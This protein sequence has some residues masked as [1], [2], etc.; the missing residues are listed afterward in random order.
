MD[1]KRCLEKI[2]KQVILI[3]VLA[4]VTSAR[5]SMLS[6]S[7]KNMDTA[8]TIQC[9][10]RLKESLNQDIIDLTLPS[11]LTIDTLHYY[12]YV[13][14]LFS[15]LGHDKFLVHLE[16]VNEELQE[17][18]VLIFDQFLLLY[19]WGLSISVLKINNYKEFE[20]VLESRSRTKNRCRCRVKN[21]N[22]YSDVYQQMFQ[23]NK[24]NYIVK[25]FYRN[26]CN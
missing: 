14:Y 24:Y 15:Y 13:N 18:K 4:N 26:C 2:I 7:L 11:D 10:N 6:D 12:W 1:A 3:I 21:P 16:W 17:N 8:Q 25:Y 19:E 22:T 20:E 23:K 9:Y 5:E